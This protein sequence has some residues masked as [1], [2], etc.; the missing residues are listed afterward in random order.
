MPATARTFWVPK[1]LDNEPAYEDAFAVNAERGTAALADGV[2][3][4]IFSGAWARALTEAAA[5][6]PP[7]VEEPSFWDWLAACRQQWRGQLDL[8]K[9]NYF[10]R[11]KLRQ[12][13]GAYSTLLWCQWADDAEHPAA[14]TW[15]ARATGDTGLLHVRG[16]ELLT[17]FPIATAAELA[18]DPQTI[19]ST[20]GRA[21]EHLAFRTAN[22]RA[23]PGDWL[24]LCTDALLGWALAEVEAGRPPD[25]QEWWDYEADTFRA[26]VA[27]LRD[28]RLMR[29][30]DTT[31]ILLRVEG[32]AEAEADPT[33][34]QT[35]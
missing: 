5:A 28:E 7:H 4:A 16:R 15:E 20:A 35:K 10:Q 22:G 32:R 31:L 3:S 33:G 8:G 2:S 24:V 34:I 14:L 11:E 12:V 18:G 21:D 13:G 25:W 6:D 19:C 17:A 30:D 1:D 9:L 26:R 29:F 23:E 27:A